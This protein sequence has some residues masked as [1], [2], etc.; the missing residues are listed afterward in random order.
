MGNA[1]HI[2]KELKQYLITGFGDDI[3]DVILF[4]SQASGKAT[5]DSDFDI[6]VVV[7]NDYNWQMRERIMD[8]AFDIGLKYQV[9]F[10]IHLLSLNEKRNSLRGKEPLIVNAIERGIYA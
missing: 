1:I 9:L 8:K 5:E 3:V 7:A 4:G 2:L 6:L 10:D